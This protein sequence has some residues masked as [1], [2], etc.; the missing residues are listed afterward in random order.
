MT[1]QENYRTE[2]QDQIERNLDRGW[3]GDL[4]PFTEFV[5][6][7]LTK[8]LYDVINDENYNK[9]TFGEWEDLLVN[10]DNLVDMLHR[11]RE[12]YENLPY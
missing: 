1:T 10:K 4:E 7:A 6:V 12:Y 3:C 2:L 11:L 9:P 8:H 5:S